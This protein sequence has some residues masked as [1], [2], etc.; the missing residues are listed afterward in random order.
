LAL[1]PVLDPDL[2][3]RARVASVKELATLLDILHRSLA[4][5]AEAVVIREVGPRSTYSLLDPST[6]LGDPGPR[7]LAEIEASRLS[8][9]SLFAPGTAWDRTLARWLSWL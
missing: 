6:S 1:L 2:D 4:R 8:E 7:A 5:P 3:G 9:T